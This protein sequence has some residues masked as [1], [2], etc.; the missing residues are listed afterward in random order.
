MDSILQDGIAFVLAFQSLGGWLELPMQF[1]TFLGSEEFFLMVL[2]ALYWSI[3]AGLGARVGIILLLTAGINDV[4]KLF[5]HGPRPYWVSADVKA[6][7]A[8]PT[9]GVPSN[10]AQTAVSMWGMFAVYIKHLWAWVAAIVVIL[11]VGLSRIYLGVHF[12]HDVLLGWLI[13]AL[14]LW[15]FLSWSDALAAWLKTK[16]LAVQVGLAF[17]LSI[18]MLAASSSVFLSLQGWTP[19]AEWASNAI[20]DGSDEPFSPVNLD[21]VLTLTGV[22]F[23]LAA[24][25]AWVNSTGGFSAD[26]PVRQRVIRYFVGLVGILVLWYILGRIFPRE[27]S[28]L[29][30]SLR[31]IRY[32]LVG[33]WISAGAPF[34][35]LRLRLAGRPSPKS[36]NNAS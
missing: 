15:A 33:F 7:S 36:S 20:R 23:G 1:F 8:E 19:P 14:G 31:Y 9:F 18:L 32:T 13:G 28:L 30:Y 29:A 11:L 6:F 24:G 26:G 22:T 25:L 21:N 10:H 35:F 2:P 17:V 5:F 27:A 12:P 34:L 4:L 3:H 16:S